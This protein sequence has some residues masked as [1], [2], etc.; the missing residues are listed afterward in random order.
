[1]EYRCL[2]LKSGKEK[3]S[4][5]SSPPQDFCLSIM[6]CIDEH[7]VRPQS[8]MQNAFVVTKPRQ[9]LLYWLRNPR[10]SPSFSQ[11]NA[12][13]RGISQWVSSS[14]FC[15]RPVWIAFL[16]GTQKKIFFFFVHIIKFCN[17]KGSNFGHQINFSVWLISV[18]KNAHIPCKTVHQCKLFKQCDLNADRRYFRILQSR[19]G[20]YGPKVISRY[21][22]TI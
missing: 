22:Y 3:A 9:P 7:F 8:V 13:I 21:I 16:C 10:H 15:F 5:K 4:K 19:A 12:I 1:M 6:T 11:C 18:M 20:R 14:E 17:F 2:F